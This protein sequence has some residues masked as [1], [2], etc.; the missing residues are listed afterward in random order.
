MN[1][2]AL[3]IRQ[4]VTVAVG[5]ILVI[6]AGLIALQRIPIQLTPNVEDTI[7]SVT[8][9]WEGAS[10]REI[11][12]EI[13]DNQED[14]LQGLAN[15]LSMTSSSQQ[16]VGRI[17]LEFAVGT[18]KEDALR[19]VSD[20]LREVPRY[21][22]NADEPVIE[23]SDPEN[24]DYIAWIVFETTDPELDIRTLLDF[25]EDRIKPV[26]ERVEGMAEVNVLGGREREAQI[27]YD[28]MLL[29]QRGIPL[30]ELVAAIRRTNRNL[31][32]GDVADAK[33]DVRVRTVSQ[34]ES[35]A[36]VKRTVVRY[37]AAGPV[38]LGDVADVVE[39]FKEP[40]SFVRSRGRSVIAINAQREVGANVMEVMAGLKEEVAALNLPGGVL[41][42]HARL[43]NL[44]GELRLTQVYDQTIYIDDALA[45][46][47]NNIWIGG[48]LAITVLL[49]FL[50]S[51]RSA[52][53]IALAIPISVVGAIVAMVA[54]GRS[55][56]VISLAGMAFAV[57]MVVDNAIVVLEN[58]YRHLE[59]GKPPREAAIEGAREVWVAILAATLTTIAVFIPILLVEEE[60]G[61]LFRDIALAI[62]AAVGLSLVVSITVIPSAAARIMRDRSRKGGASGDGAGK[63]RR[64]PRAAGRI[65][66]AIAGFIYWLSGSV[67]A[68]LGI[69]ILLTAISFG[70]T[71]FLMPPADYLPQGNRN[72]VF[73]LLIPPSGYN[74][75]QR[76]ELASR[77]EVGLR[78]FWEAGRLDRASDARNAA[79]KSL[80]AV[81]TFDWFALAPGDPV[82]PPPLKNYFTVSF[83]DILFHGGISDDP[84]RAVDLIPLFQHATRADLLPGVL[85]FA[86]QVPLFSLG[87]T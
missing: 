55:I 42:A 82:V 69:V 43:M 48:A 21:P 63:P 10:P 84:K 36:E 27:R 13:V 35:V 83:E 3:A 54:M 76:S 60:A 85:A 64:E 32:A 1:L 49:L 19:E 51:L 73:G 79:E 80:P 9:F 4:P 47:R 87:G 17:R 72:L 68:R 14:K 22:E 34:Y 52:G 56:N 41:D 57:G 61:Q 2:S 37:T 67:L 6:L 26:L 59:M 44:D 75:D 45:L 33:R 46:V 70:G 8:T 81:P 77:I 86:F 74:L 78:P 11:E 23:A 39:T 71:W 18:R 20:K 50:R 38:F 30:S 40:R 12:Q 62:C 28:P 16:G 66:G 5:I 24:R 31:S 25:A 15:L 65:P 53:I 58:I 7:I 29:A